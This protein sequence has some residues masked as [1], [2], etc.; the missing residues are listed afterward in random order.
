MIELIV[1]IFVDHVLDLIL[2]SQRA[3]NDQL[4][5]QVSLLAAQAVQMKSPVSMPEKFS[6]QID[7]FPAFMGQCQLFIS[8]RPEDFPTDR[9]KV[10]FMISLLTGQAANWATPLLVQDSPLLNNFQGHLQ[11]MRLSDFS[12]VFSE[13]E[14]DRLPPHR[15]YDCPVDLIPDAPLPK[16][17]LYSMSEPELVALREFLD[18]NLARGFI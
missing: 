6:G 11:Q 9:S 2:C 5:Q 8:L 12:N 4:A 7:R 10:G 17:R 3:D 1:T 15:A 16:G 13:Q 18:K 14:A